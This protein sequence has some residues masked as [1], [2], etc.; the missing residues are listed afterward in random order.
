MF[1]EDFKQAWDSQSSRVRLTVNLEQLDAETRDFQQRFT[2]RLF[3]RDLREIGIG[4]SLVPVWLF[5]GANLKLP[6]TWYLMIPALIWIVGYLLVDRMRTKPCV[7]EAGASLCGRLEHLLTQI[8][9]QIRLLNGVT[10]WCLVPMAVP[11]LAF[12][13]QVAL[14]D[15]PPNLWTAVFVSEMLVCIGGVFAVV[16]YLNQTAVRTELIPRRDELR[17]QL[18][19]LRDESADNESQIS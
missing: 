15:G 2:K 12:V 16:H 14:K 13:S 10:W 5:L 8:E 18:Q 6:W 17:S 1:P 11:M 3:W 7:P 4:L 19:N 9:Q